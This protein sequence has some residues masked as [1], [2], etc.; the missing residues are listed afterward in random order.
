LPRFKEANMSGC[1]RALVLISV[2]LLTQQLA[3]AGESIDLTPQYQ[4]NGLMHVSIQLD[5]GGHDLIRV[6][7][8]DKEAPS[9]KKLPSS[10]AA[11]LGYD[12]LRLSDVTAATTGTPLAIRYYDTAEA[13]I[14]V[15]SSGRAPKLADDR[16]LIVLAQS[17]QRPALYCPD[18]PLD[19][20]QLDLIDV[21]GDS[22]AVDHL[23]PSKQVAEG[24]TWNNDA[25]VM[26]PLLTFDTVAVCEVQS[27]LDS[28]NENYAKIR[29]A[30]V[31]HGTADGAGIEQE[32]RGVYLFDRR[33]HRVT[34]LNLAVREERAI[35]GATPGLDAVAKLQVVIEPIA[36][37]EHLT[38]DVVGRLKESRPA[39]IHNLS[40]EAPKLGFRVQHDRQ[41]Y[42]T[43]ETRQAVTL[44]RVDNGD[45]AA[46]CTITQLPSKSAGRQAS[47]EQFQKDVEYSLGKNFSELVSSRQWRNKAGLFCYEI[48]AR[49][50]VEQVPMEWHSYLIAPESGPRVSVVVTMEGRMVDRV[51]NADSELVES[52]QLFPA[53]PETQTALQPG[54]Q[55]VK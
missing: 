37:S 34:R 44:R 35:G 17:D 19:R 23:L 20:K 52:L 8:D 9:E 36:K 46:Q 38:D 51:A 27:V 24:A 14:K 47:L 54:G 31:V 5:V 30:G 45:L 6:P 4:L 2:V 12:E 15:D 41:W 33:L 28:W 13:V 1:R 29:L 21:V 16:R 42:D 49:G 40:F 43:A 39:S 3:R 55:T 18:A 22:F 25:T 11:K 26:G 10:V 53:V 32:V 48:V 50:A 7:G